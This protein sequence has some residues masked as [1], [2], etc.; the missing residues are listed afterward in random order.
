MKKAHWRI[1][2]VIL[3][4][5]IVSLLLRSFFLIDYLNYSLNSDQANKLVL[6]YAKS[7]ELPAYYEYQNRHQAKGSNSWVSAT[8]KLARTTPSYA[9]ALAQYFQVAQQHEQAEY[10]YLQAISLGNTAANY[11]LA[12]MFFTQQRY[13]KASQLL[14]KD[15]RLGW[16]TSSFKALKLAIELA[17]I[18]G[19]IENAQKL[20]DF[21]KQSYA[22][23]PLAKAL[24]YELA[25]F[26]VA[27]SKPS[28]NIMSTNC[29]ASVQMFATNLDDLRYVQQLIDQ[30]NQHPLAEFVCFSSPRYISMDELACQ[31][32]EDDVIQCR[33]DIWQ[34][35][36]STISTRF[37]GVLLPQGGANVNHGIMY[38][39]RQDTFA[40]FIHELTHLLGFIDEYPLPTNHAK[41]LSAQSQSFSHNIAVLEPIYYGER[42]TLREQVLRHL[43]WGSKIE[44]QTPIFM[45]YHEGWKLGTPPKYQ[46]EIGVF[47]SNTCA[48]ERGFSDN[49]GRSLQAVKPISQMTQ[50]EYFEMP[51]PKQ[52]I[53]MLRENPNKYLMPSFHTNIQNAQM[54]R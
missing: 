41:C 17:L 7:I 19:N 20:S 34:Q 39:D 33:E 37:I 14:S 9:I 25:Y 24:T 27:S 29:V 16:E 50:L 54:M 8:A 18:N 43:A 21:L 11:A 51:L 5:V 45:Q 6:S 42:E 47:L 30:I 38:L 53:D 13:E 32:W 48:G 31:H 2:I 23:D 22:Y 26:G 1:V 28:P 10:W 46:G 36:E 49:T 15:S 3:M 12:Q 40:V 4:S 52:Y 35:H 44:K